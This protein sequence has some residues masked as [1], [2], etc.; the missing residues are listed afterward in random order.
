VLRRTWVQ[1]YVTLA[2][3]LQ[4][5]EP[6]NMPPASAQVESPHEPEAR[7]GTKRDRSWIG[8]KVHVSES[9][10]DDRPHLLTHVETTIAPATDVEQ[11]VLLRGV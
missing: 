6:K 8:Y 2:G 5:R 10:D 1:Q 11:L 4:L 7:Y 3:V 9:C